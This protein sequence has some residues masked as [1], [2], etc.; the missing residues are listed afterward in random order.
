MG[1]SFKGLEKIVREHFKQ[2]PRSGDYFLF[3][4]T[5]HTYAK[6][7]RCM[8]NGFKIVARKLD[9]GSFL[10]PGTKSIDWNALKKL[11]SGLDEDA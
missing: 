5:S 10:I 7:L 4:N 9:T 1:L 2:D 11:I 8:G 6:L 3:Y